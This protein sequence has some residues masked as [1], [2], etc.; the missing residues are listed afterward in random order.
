MLSSVHD[1][2][3]SVII[4]YYIY[5]NFVAQSHTARM[6]LFQV[7][8]YVVSKLSPIYIIIMQSLFVNSRNKLHGEKWKRINI[9][10]HRLIGASLKYKDHISPPITLYNVHSTT[11]QQ[12][13]RPCSLKT[14][15]V[16]HIN[17]SLSM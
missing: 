8:F 16:T 15:K 11:N 4:A 10:P 5:S 6:N 12:H 9:L 1:K 13:S 7:M 3:Q 17:S 2:H 14:C